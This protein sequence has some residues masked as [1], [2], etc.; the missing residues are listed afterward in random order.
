MMLSCIVAMSENFVIGRDND[1]P[2][3]L[4]A[5]LKRFKSLTTDHSIIMGRKTYESIGRPLPRRT[6]IVLSRNPDFEASGVDGASTDT[7]AVVVVADLDEALSC[8]EGRPGNDEAFIIGGSA[9]FESALPRSQRLH[10]TLVHTELEG[11]VFFPMQELE[12]FQLISS[13]RHDADDRHAFAY[14]FRVY[15]RV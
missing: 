2:W 1:L 9:V 14:S 12:K 10:L 8:A 4:P 6:S 11:D 5:D 15:E 3:H 13:D 7:A